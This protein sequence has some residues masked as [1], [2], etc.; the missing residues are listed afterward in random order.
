MDILDAFVHC[1]GTA[2]SLRGVA[3]SLKR[4]KPGI[5]IFAV[6]PVESPVL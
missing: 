5:R 4:H 6:E 1:V 2:A 3:A